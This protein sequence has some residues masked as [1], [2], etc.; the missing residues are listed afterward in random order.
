MFT[1]DLV[2][3]L[4]KRYTPAKRGSFE[5]AMIRERV[6]AGLHRARAEGKRLDGEWLLFER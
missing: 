2:A 4:R 6:K 5:R 3:T 1:P